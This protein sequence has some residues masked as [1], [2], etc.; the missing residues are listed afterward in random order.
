MFFRW[1]GVQTFDREKIL[2]QEQLREVTLNDP[3]LIREILAALLDDASE[4]MEQIGGAIAEGNVDSCRRLAHSSK[5][6][7]ANL[8]AYAL[9]W[10]LHEMEDMAARGE[11]AACSRSL[12]SLAAELE[13][14][15]VEVRG[16]LGTRDV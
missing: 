8:G 10:K 6:A 1:I 3:E 13:R 4:K 14:L 11:V 16:E 15:R 2:D 7:C 9:A 12:G 5:G